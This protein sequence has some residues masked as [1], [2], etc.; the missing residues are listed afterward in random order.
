MAE[1]ISSKT[2]S[3]VAQRAGHICEYCR[4]P[5]AFSSSKFSV[6]H[7]IPR[8]NGGSD[9]IDNLAFASNGTALCGESGVP[10]LGDVFGWREGVEESGRF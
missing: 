4:T 5:S 8:I 9:S 7:I 2:K 3:V 6:E 1:F 10:V